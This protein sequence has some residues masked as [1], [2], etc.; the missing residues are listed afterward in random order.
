MLPIAEEKRFF[1]EYFKTPLN[2]DFSRF[3]TAFGGIYFNPKN[4]REFLKAL[5][6]ALKKENFSVI[7]I[8]IDSKESKNI[9][10]RVKKNLIDELEKY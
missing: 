6:T 3:V 9:R 5:N 10:D 8:N 4:R 2:L 1:N 7:Q